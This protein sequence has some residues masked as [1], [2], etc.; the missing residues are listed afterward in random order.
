MNGWTEVCVWLGIVGAFALVNRV[1]VGPS[2]RHPA[3]WGRRSR[4]SDL[5]DGATAVIVGK[6]RFARGS[7][8]APLSGRRVCY[9]DA[10]CHHED[11]GYP[12]YEAP[13]PPAVRERRAL[14]FVVED[15]TGTALIR[16]DSGAAFKRAE[17]MLPRNAERIRAFL[18]QSDDR[19]N[20]FESVL[21]EDAVVAVYGIGEWAPAD[22]RTVPFAGYREAP[23][24]LVMRAREVR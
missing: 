13:A 18:G 23:R 9:Y 8:E 21:E 12:Y 19:W 11:S 7:L 14:D 10:G 17:R 5:G 3:R 2:S 6:I 22:N 4:I 20:A 16:V 15:D 1:S 24:R